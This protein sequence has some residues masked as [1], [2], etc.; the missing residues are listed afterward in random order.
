MD[1]IDTTLAGVKLIR[2]KRFGDS[3][4]YFSE[5]YNRRAFAQFI[6]EPIDFVQD[7]LAYSAQPGTV[8]GLHFQTPPF[9]QDKL[10]SVLRGKIFDVALDIRRGSPTY[11]RHVVAVLDGTR[12]DQLFVPAGFAHGYCTMEPECLVFY[13]VSNF[14]S[15]QSEA[16]IAWN[17]PALEIAWPV[18]PNEAELS[19]KDR[20]WPLLRDMDSP[21]EFPG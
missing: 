3:R 2:P 20:T 13:K 19:V 6:A 5:T 16:G 7:N 10:V 12:S 1:I 14:Y 8:R 9:A 11:G 21:F 15:P 4:G 17:D 18:D